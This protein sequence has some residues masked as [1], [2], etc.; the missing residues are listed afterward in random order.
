M[1]EIIHHLLLPFGQ[2]RHKFP[3]LHTHAP[4]CAKL[5]IPTINYNDAA[6][7]R[8]SGEIAIS[9]NRG[10]LGRIKRRRI[11]HPRDSR[12]RTSRIVVVIASRNRA[13]SWRRSIFNTHFEQPIVFA[14]ATARPS[15]SRGYLAA[16]ALACDALR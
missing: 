6:L 15:P 10:S 16:Q 3:F 4:K 12:R 1:F 14:P 11:L 7:W 2:S 8:K 13:E 5:S 9:N